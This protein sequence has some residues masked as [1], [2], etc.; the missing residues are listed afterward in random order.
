[1]KIQLVITVLMLTAAASMVAMCR[2]GK[3]QRS[4]G[5]QVASGNNQ[6]NALTPVASIP[7]R[8]EL[9]KEH[10]AQLKRRGGC[11][12]GACAQ[13]QAPAAPTTQCANGACALKP[14]AKQAGKVVYT[15]KK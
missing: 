6:G 8:M 1:M 11:A 7:N 3:C 14:A 15:A 5:R 4:A 13:A 2:D 10:A 9:V 12:N